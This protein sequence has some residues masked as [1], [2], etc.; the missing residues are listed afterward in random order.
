MPFHFVVKLKFVVAFFLS[1]FIDLFFVPNWTHSHEMAESW[2]IY[3]LFR[4]LV[5]FLFICLVYKSHSHTECHLKIEMCS[6][7]F[8]KHCR[9]IALILTFCIWHQFDYNPM[10]LEN[11]CCVSRL[12]HFFFS[13]GRVQFAPAICCAVKVL[14]SVRVTIWKIK[15]NKNSYK[16]NENS[17]IQAFEWEREK[18]RWMKYRWSNY[19]LFEIFTLKFV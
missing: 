12:S 13:F 10:R 16:M 3:H 17:S 19:T 11:L 18:R 2:W 14:S 4:L 5:Y 9:F 6:M 1:Q 7:A 15:V 8:G